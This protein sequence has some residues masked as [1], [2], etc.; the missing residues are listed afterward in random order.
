MALKVF[1]SELNKEL[2]E[3][4]SHND[5]YNVEATSI[6]EK[7]KDI[8]KRYIF[9]AGVV[10]ADPDLERECVL[11]AFS[12]NPTE[13]S[14]DLVCHLNEF[15]GRQMSEHKQQKFAA[16]HRRLSQSTISDLTNFIMGPR[17]K[18]LSWA[19]PWPQLQ[20]ECA[21]LVRTEKKRRIVEHSTASANEKLKF[22]HL[23]YDDFKDMAPLELPGIQKGYE[24]YVP[25][26]DHGDKQ[27][28]KG[29][30]DD[31][32][33]APESKEWIRKEHKRRQNK[34]RLLKKRGQKLMEMSAEGKM[35]ATY[36]SEKKPRRARSI[37]DSLKPARPSKAKEPKPI[38]LPAGV[39]PQNTCDIKLEKL[40]SCTL[41]VVVTN[42]VIHANADVNADVNAYVN[43][44]VNADVNVVAN[45]DAN[46][47]AYADT[48]PYVNRIMNVPETMTIRQANTLYAAEPLTVIESGPIQHVNDS[49]QPQSYDSTWQLPGRQQP[50]MA[51]IRSGNGVTNSAQTHTHTIKIEPM[52]SDDAV[53]TIA[54]PMS[55]VPTIGQAP[56]K[57]TNPLL[58]FRKPKKNKMGITP[59]DQVNPAP[60]ELQ[61]TSNEL[62]V[63]HN[64]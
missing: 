22:V 64:F 6:M 12:M 46:T 17:F 3:L 52:H 15:R 9:L 45:A 30:T 36:P 26:S 25:D 61:L 44:D 57:A 49:V 8:S 60:T 39:L 29:D 32:D 41:D 62:K 4:A 18:R 58:L 20:L 47:N 1:F 50:N 28:S 37:G 43:A 33:S 34:R 2:N 56:A 53:H 27:M 7:E 38:A 59:S 14:F 21:E 31:T 5:D 40:D 63:I 19:L 24:M 48:D 13:D 11:T 55:F 10:K 23:N 35:D 51:D 54:S 16:W 42:T